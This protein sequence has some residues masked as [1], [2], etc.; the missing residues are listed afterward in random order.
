MAEVKSD[1]KLVLKKQEKEIFIKAI[2]AAY[3]AGRV[4]GNFIHNFTPQ[5]IQGQT[6]CV[7][8]IVADFISV[9]K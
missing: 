3:Q 4:D 5:L 2:S 9:D 7:K 8:K 6:A 1:L